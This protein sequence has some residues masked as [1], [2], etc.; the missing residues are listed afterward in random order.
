MKYKSLGQSDKGMALF[1][2]RGGLRETITLLQ[3]Q[4]LLLL[5]SHDG[6]A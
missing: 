4:L 5:G 6:V 3:L 1:A 2:L